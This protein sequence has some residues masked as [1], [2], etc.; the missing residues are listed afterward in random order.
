MKE[1]TGKESTG[2]E[3]KRRRE[4]TMERGRREVVEKKEKKEREEEDGE[5]EGNR[6][7]GK[8]RG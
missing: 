1:S 5:G 6:K 8:E 2:K 4:W 3:R 7:C